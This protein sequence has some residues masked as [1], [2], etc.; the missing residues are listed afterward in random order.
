[1]SEVPL[2]PV[3]SML[4]LATRN[5][6]VVL[7]TVVGLWASLEALWVVGSGK[8]LQKGGKV[9]LVVWTWRLVLKCCFCEASGL[10]FVVWG[11]RRRVLGF[12]VQGFRV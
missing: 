5:P 11:V 1:M 2:Y 8:Q 3:Q 4:E 10:G 9:G 7:S 6:C 12:R